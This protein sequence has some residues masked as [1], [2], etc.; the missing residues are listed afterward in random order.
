[1]TDQPRRLGDIVILA[2]VALVAVFGVSYV[3]SRLALSGF[4]TARADGGGMMGRGG[5]G[6]MG[7]GDMMGNGGMMG[8][9][10]AMGGAVHSATSGSVKKLEARLAEEATIDSATNTITYH[11]RQVQLVALGSPEGQ[12]DMTWNIEGR[13][14]PTVVVPRGAR[15]TV[16]FFNADA[17]HQHG[18]ELT[19][20]PPPYRLMAMMYAAV[21]RPGA[22]AMP[23]R[24]TGSSHWFGRT[25]H[26][27]AITA[28]T[29]YYLCPVPGHA[30]R[31]MYGKLVVR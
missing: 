22:F 9:G 31:G 11:T 23:V 13:V 30:Q 17:D 14:N 16:H 15:V 29:F 8:S 19:T 5:S 6:M 26:F 3:A 24:A 21:A 2:I 1:M 7:S 4:Q 28:G 12:R 27:T 25:L 18:W 10:S 20:T